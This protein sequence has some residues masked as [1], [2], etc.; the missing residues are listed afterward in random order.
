M[1]PVPHKRPNRI[2]VDNHVL[3]LA[4]RCR[5]VWTTADGR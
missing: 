2:Q 4:L 1:L 5:V 3:L